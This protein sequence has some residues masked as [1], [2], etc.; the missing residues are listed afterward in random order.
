MSARDELKAMIQT[1]ACQTT[2]DPRNAD[3]LI[4]AFA[5]ELAEK[6]RDAAQESVDAAQE[7]LSGDGELFAADLIDPEVA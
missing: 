7:V 2:Q 3:A 1:G 4:D 6:I 5:H